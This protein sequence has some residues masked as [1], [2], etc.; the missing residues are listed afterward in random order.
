MFWTWVFFWTFS[1]HQKIALP[2]GQCL[3]IGCLG[4]HFSGAAQNRHGEYNPLLKVQP[5]STLVSGEKMLDTNF[6]PSRLWIPECLVINFY[7]YFYIGNYQTVL[8]QYYMYC[9]SSGG[10][11]HR[12][13]STETQSSIQFLTNC[14]LQFTR[15]RI[16]TEKVSLVV[17]LVSRRVFLDQGDA[18]SLPES[19][20]SASNWI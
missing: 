8:W 4:Y 2:T 5:L 12:L 11:F 9:H 18:T 3:L 19:L 20:R 13:S 6:S 10:Y 14:E 1:W 16:P 7:S 17:L 15:K